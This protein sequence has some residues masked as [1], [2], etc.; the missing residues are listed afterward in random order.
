MELIP[1]IRMDHTNVRMLV[2]PGLE[3]PNFKYPGRE[4]PDHLYFQW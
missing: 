2:H 3:P 4:R 1:G